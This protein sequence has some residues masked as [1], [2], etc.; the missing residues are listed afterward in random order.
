MS[1]KFPPYFWLVYV[2]LSVFTLAI[3][4]QTREFEFL[5]WDDDLFVTENPRVTSGLAEENFA[6]SFGIHGPGQW[7]PMAWWVHQFNCQVFGLEPGAHHLVN[8]LLHV[9]VTLVL[10]TALWRLTGN[11]WPSA[12]VAAL[13]A[14][15]HFRSNR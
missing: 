9:A 3:Y 12:F 10:M 6:W 14:L 1:L 7:H 13:H 15:H 2:V 5:N 4:W 8:V 11:F